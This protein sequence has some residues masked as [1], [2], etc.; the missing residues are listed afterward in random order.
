MAV[1]FSFQLSLPPS[2]HILIWV[3]FVQMQEMAAVSPSAVFEWPRPRLPI[4]P[5]MRFNSI[6]RQLPA[7]LNP[8]WDFKRTEIQQLKIWPIT[9]PLQ[10]WKQAVNGQQR[11]RIKKRRPERRKAEFLQSNGPKLASTSPTKFQ[12]PAFPPPSPPLPSKGA[13]ITC[14]LI[15]WRSDRCDRSDIFRF[16]RSA[17]HV[18]SNIH[19]RQSPAI[20]PSCRDWGSPVGW[21]LRAARII[22]HS[23]N[24]NEIES[25][26]LKRVQL[27]NKSIN[28]KQWKNIS[29]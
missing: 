29:F 28:I 22:S 7:H 24:R 27:M 4:H 16:S 6:V 13:L 26:S 15:N 3:R 21:C 8:L 10:R 25:R 1:F 11:A 5:W 12:F 20:R 23:S 18:Q 19:D 9:F 2:L 14:Q 17:G